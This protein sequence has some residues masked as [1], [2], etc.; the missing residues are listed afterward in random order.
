MIRS[1]GPGRNLRVKLFAIKIHAHA[2]TLSVAPPRDHD[3]TKCR[4]AAG[5]I[6][7]AEGGAGMC[8]MAGWLAAS[9][10][11]TTYCT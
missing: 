3:I 2:H 4:A 8:L 9:G 5:K 10:S 11:S 1:Y 7:A 6:M